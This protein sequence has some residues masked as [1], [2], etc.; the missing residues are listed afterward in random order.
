MEEKTPPWGLLYN[1]SQDELKVLKKYL[2]K[3]LSKGFIRTSSFLAISLI[4]F[5]YKL[6]S[7]LR[8]CVDYRQLNAMTIKNWYPLP[9]IKETL[10]R[11]C[12]LKIYS[13]INIIATFNH[14]HIY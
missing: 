12:K 14:L 1:M 6:G 11:I 4:L 2:K 8:F 9:L 7:G 13:K 5:A 10:E 3:N